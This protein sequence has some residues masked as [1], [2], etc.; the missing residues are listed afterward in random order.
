[1]WTE[2]FNEFITL[3]LVI[4]P[5][6][7]LPS[8][9]ALTRGFESKSQYKIA[10]NAVLVAFLV[11]IFFIFGGSV[12]LRHMDVPLR[13]FQIAGG[14]ML[15]VVALEMLRGKEEEL[16][17][18]A[19]PEQQFAIAVYPLAIPRIAGPGAMLAVILLTDDDRH[20]VQG[21]LATVGVLG[22]VMVIQLVLLFAA[23]PIQRLIGNSVVTVIGR[24]MA[25]LLAALAVSLVLKAVGDWLQLPAL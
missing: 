16:T 25:L 11:L 3:L 17:G 24:V 9:L 8:Y 18:E 21:Q 15:F 7:A 14:I 6:E 12:L 5:I 19:T 22:L 4:N 10:I 20:N 1:M 2:R 23:L 13:A